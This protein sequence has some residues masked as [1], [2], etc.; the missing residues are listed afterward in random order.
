MEINY[1]RNCSACK[2][3]IGF[4]SVYFECSVS[5]CSRPRTGL[6]FCSVFCW[7]THLPGARHKDAGALEKQAPSKDQWTIQNSATPSSPATSAATEAARSPVRKIISGQSAVNSNL[8]PAS[9]EV[10]VVVSKLK[11]YIRERSEMNTSDSVMDLLSDKLRALC[12]EAIESAR[13]DGR[14]TVMDRDF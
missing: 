7:E 14:K 12:D 2:K 13:A 9:K 10:L 8:K 11:S 5:T 4:R 6:V 3:P 1:W